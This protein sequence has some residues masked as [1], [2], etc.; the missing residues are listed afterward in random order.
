MAN[1]FRQFL[2]HINDKSNSVLWFSILGTDDFFV[3]LFFI[4][5]LKHLLNHLLKALCYT[6]MFNYIS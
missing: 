3:K 6:F 1:S 4:F 2:L 5:I